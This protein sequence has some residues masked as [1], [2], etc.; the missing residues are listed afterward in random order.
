[1]RDII[2]GV[3]FIAI[4]TLFLIGSLNYTIG[5]VLSIGP[6]FL[7]TFTSIGLIVLGVILIVREVMWKS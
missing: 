3:L 5:T 1:M 6:G 2:T 4:G 7:P